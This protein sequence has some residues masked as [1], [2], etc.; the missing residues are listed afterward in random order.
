MSFMFTGCKKMDKLILNHFNTSKVKNMMA[1]FANCHALTDVQISSFN[2]E[3]ATDISAM[4]AGCKALTS[5]D[6]SNFN[7][8]NSFSQML[9]RAIPEYVDILFSNETEAEAYTGKPAKEA[10]SEIMKEVE[11]AI[12][13][14]GK[15]GALAGH[16]GKTVHVPAVSH[17]PV[18]TTGAG[19]NFAAG[20]L[21]GYSRGASLQ[22]SAEIGA[23]MA[24]NVVETVGPQI[25]PERWEQITSKVSR[26]LA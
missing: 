12:V 24:G 4:F 25:A 17:N 9:H 13:T 6:L 14:V 20:F 16:A 11:Y 2:T 26:I 10:I 18:D 1:M 19:D 3:Q 22:Q 21:Y 23:L 8:V 5:L 7:I 15:D